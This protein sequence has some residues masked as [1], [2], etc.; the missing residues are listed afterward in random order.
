MLY[1]FSRKTLKPTIAALLLAV[2]IGPQLII[3]SVQA[4][5][6]PIPQSRVV[7]QGVSTEVLMTQATEQFHRG[8]LRSAIALFEQAH[9]QYHQANDSLGT[10]RALTQL[11]RIYNELNQPESA[12]EVLASAIALYATLDSPLDQAEALIY[13]GVAEGKLGHYD[14]ARTTLQTAL[15]IYQS[16][17]FSHTQERQRLIGEGQAL[18]SLGSLNYDLDE[19]PQAIAAHTTALERF[20]TVGDTFETMATLLLL[21]LTYIPAGDA[22]QALDLTEQVTTIAQ[23]HQYDAYQGG[24]LFVAGLAHQSLKE[25]P[26]AID[27]LQQSLGLLRQ[28]DYRLETGYVTALLANA[29]AQQGNHD[30]AVQLAGEALILGQDLA[31]VETVSA[32]LGIILTSSI[33]SNDRLG[34]FDTLTRMLDISR[35]LES[36]D[37]EITSLFLLAFLNLDASKYEL[38]LAYSQQL[39]EVSQA[40]NNR[41]YEGIALALIAGYHVAHKDVDTA[42]S[43]AQS[44][45]A[46]AAE[47]QSPNIQSLALTYLASAYGL[48]KDYVQ[49]I[50]A[51]TQA[52]EIAVA[53]NNGI[54][55][56]PLVVLIAL[57]KETEQYELITHFSDLTLEAWQ[58][59]Q[60]FGLTDA[61]ITVATALIKTEGKA[62]AISYVQ[63]MLK[64]SQQLNDPSAEAWAWMTLARLYFLIEDYPNFFTTLDQSLA[65]AKASN[66]TFVASFSLFMGSVL[67]FKLGQFES[68]LDLAEQGIVSAQYTNDQN[69]TLLGLI[70]ISANHYAQGNFSQA[71]MVSDQGLSQSQA[72]QSTE[73][74]IF[75]L[76]QI[77]LNYLGLKN[78][79]QAEQIA[80]QALEQAQTLTD[81]SYQEF[82]LNLLGSIYAELGQIDQA[83]D[84]Y[85]AALALDTDG[86]K[87]TSYFGLA[88]IY[89]DL[90][91]PS[92]AITYY[93]EAINEIEQ[94]RLRLRSLSLNLQASYL[95]S[96]MGTQ[97]VRLADIYRELAD[98]LLSEGRVLEAQA[99]LE[100]LKVQELQQF[101]EASRGE[102]N[103][104]DLAFNTTEDQIRREHGGL[105]AFG[106]TL[107]TCETNPACDP[108]ELNHLYDQQQVLTR[109]FNTTM[110][111][112]EDQVRDRIR[113]DRA[114]LDTE[115]FSRAAQ[116]IVE[117]EPNSVLIYPLVLDDKL[118]LLWAAPGGVVGSQEI[119]D[120]GQKRLGETVLKFR[121]LLQDPNS[122][123]VEL[124]A[125]GYQ[126]YQ[127]LVQ[128]LEEELEA[129]DIHNLIFSLD[130]A[131]RYIPMSALYDGESFL[132]E[133]YTVS[134]VLSADLTDTRD[135]IPPDR[136]NVSVLALG[137]SNAVDN[138]KP[139]PNVPAELD[140]VV[141]TNPEDPI[142]IYPGQLFLNEAF[143]YRALRNNLRNHQ[144][145]HIATHGEFVPGRHT[146][147]YLV[148]GTGEY[149]QIPDIQDLQHLDTVSLVVLSACET[150]LGGPDNNGVEI[151]G[152]A[153]YFL[154]G[155]AK[156]VMASLWQVNDAS[157][158]DLMQSFYTHIAQDGVTKAKALQ[159]AQLSFIQGTAATLENPNQRSIQIEAI[160]A[161]S[162]RSNPANPLSHP[163]YWAPFILIGNSL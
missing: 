155:G 126:L 124:K 63:R 109:Q 45:L 158:R 121:Q 97:R 89:R 12:L 115:D 119:T 9:D 69:Y 140:A 132:I 112:L 138:F 154:N 108:A 17:H 129:N 162:S 130:R 85:R 161:N 65:A 25:T 47:I 139:L 103:T 113:R 40:H 149:L 128:P 84:A 92:T 38:S 99:V 76:N 104:P 118:W 30:L 44:A 24:A 159:L 79:S 148:L 51:A 105:I 31:D 59:R 80:Q 82:S 68:S 54:E 93:K 57:L 43:Y 62:S 28:S 22:Q 39:L 58:K 66:N 125:T 32:A 153:Y 36:S 64:I 100:L 46:I 48:K 88:Q 41:E 52:L 141:Q 116:R 91:L 142:G 122:D 87:Q 135:R 77:A 19:Y 111:S 42:E 94:T 120:V 50:Q 98:L 23:T 106:R 53:S 20:Q 150:A 27:A 55:H 7:A 114:T 61:M 163:Y 37:L 127:W 137:L 11:G 81:K 107:Q 147:S 73:G 60:N 110:R 15:A 6:P 123:L 5:T 10:A 72:I 71:I 3:P 2:V 34:I 8:Q 4:T 67:Y 143:D 96:F 146:D 156:S 134:T 83:T 35:D 70:M 160:E 102:D 131:A 18:R 117:A 90:G 74:Q 151:A 133:R 21:G 145:L 49:A 101:T 95:Q 13:R 33:K 144:I 29:Y 26:A 152:I 56:Y 75:N 157:T 136:A 86:T 14:E 78:Y 16:G 1:S